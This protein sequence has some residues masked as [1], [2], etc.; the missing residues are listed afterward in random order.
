MDQTVELNK[1]EDVEGKKRTWT[2]NKRRKLIK[3]ENAPKKPLNG[4]VLF[5]NARRES[6]TKQNQHLSFADVTKLL[7]EEWSSMNEKQRSVYLEPADRER[8][9]YRKK[10]EEY[11]K[12]E[13]YKKFVGKKSNVKQQ[14]C[15]V[16]AKSNEGTPNV[17]KI[18]D[19]A[20]KRWNDSN[21]PIF[22]EIF[23]D[24]NKAK[25]SELHQI[26]KTNMS[27]E[28]QNIVLDK[29][30]ANLKNAVE[31]LNHEIAEQ[32][33]KNLELENKLNSFRLLLYEAFSDIRL[34]LS[35]MLPTIDTI[36]TY[37]ADAC[38]ALQ[39]T[40]DDQMFISAVQDV[41]TKVNFQTLDVSW[42]EPDNTTDV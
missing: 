3:D 13:A 39:G 9:K 1:D 8:E 7:G 5:M 35:G 36:D 37:I 31:K 2:K 38:S 40:L 14:H 10:M 16:E 25:E 23:L 24:Y 15:T 28:K 27:Y 26:S 19:T 6:V 34:P 18:R 21:I 33:R 12:T 11:K 32:N 20:N 22:T 30:V 41:M 17:P 42:E 4:Y 29:H